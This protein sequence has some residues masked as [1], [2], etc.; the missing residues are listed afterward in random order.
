MKYIMLFYTHFGAMK[1]KK[2]F[3]NLNI[4]AKTKPTPRILSSSCGVCLEFYDELF[5]I[6]MF[7]DEEEI[8]S[9]YFYDGNE[10]IKKYES[11]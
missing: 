4:D 7:L 8:Q 3:K 11:D 5:D 9:I 2:T 10:Y 1:L 6:E